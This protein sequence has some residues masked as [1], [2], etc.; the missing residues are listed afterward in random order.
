MHASTHAEH[1]PDS[2]PIPDQSDPTSLTNMLLLVLQGQQAL[3][4][5]SMK[6][7]Q[8][9]VSLKEDNKELRSQLYS[10][11]NQLTKIV[12]E[13]NTITNQSIATISNTHSM[14]FEIV[15]KN[16]LIINDNI[17]AAKEGIQ[18]IEKE[19]GSLKEKLSS[20]AVEQKID[21]LEKTIENLHVRATLPLQFLVLKSRSSG[22]RTIH[23]R[24]NPH[25]G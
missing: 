17:K 11:L 18:I 25:K 10:G 12:T 1:T 2:I 13:K 7:E 16:S 6:M 4:S 24:D 14:D 23:A 9:I 21:N 22:S 8:E 5:N 3:L 20:S 19:I 15:Q